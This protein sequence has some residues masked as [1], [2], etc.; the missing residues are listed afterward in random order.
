MTVGTSEIKIIC[1][2][3]VS[4][5][6]YYGVNFKWHMPI[7]EEIC[8]AEQ[9][10]MPFLGTVAERVF[11]KKIQSTETYTN[12]LNAALWIFFRK[13]RSVMV[14]RWIFFQDSQIRVNSGLYYVY[15]KYAISTKICQFSG[16]SPRVFFGKNP[17]RRINL[18]IFLG[19]G[20]FHK[21]RWMT[22]PNIGIYFRFKWHIP[23]HIGICHFK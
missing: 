20:F 22:V 23:D 13:T 21:S 7:R 6:L 9:K 8:R 11:W 2:D 16:P 3:R 10:Y 18:Y 1:T 15:L 19:F 4:V 17:E 14:P 5:D 12:L